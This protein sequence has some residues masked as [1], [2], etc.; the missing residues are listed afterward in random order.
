M[1]VDDGST[2][3]TAQV[4]NRYK[5]ISNKIRVITHPTNQGVS[6]ARNTGNAHARGKYITII[7][8]DDFARPKFLE[9]V[10]SFMDKNPT[11][12][13]GIPFKD[14][15]IETTKNSQPDR[16]DYPF[17]LLVNDNSLGNVGNVFRRDFM[18]KHKIK[19]KNTYSCGEDYDFWMQMI[20]NGA[21]IARIESERSP[22]VFRAYGGLSR[23]GN[24]SYCVSQVKEQLLKKIKYEPVENIKDTCMAFW[25]VLDTFPNLLLPKDK[26]TEFTNYCP[27]RTNTYLKIKHPYWTDFLIFSTYA[28][29][30]YRHSNQDKATILSF[31]PKNKIV[32]KWEKWG[33]ETFIYNKD[34]NCYILK[35]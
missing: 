14:G 3:H 9:T 17:Y 34:L 21:Q 6:A 4:L 13:I 7:D 12:T 25:H 16:W 35:K 15:Y 23:T 29:H 30:A 18:L 5:K 31:I 27:A 10:V 24:C 22:I 2:D 1:I 20:L 32:L 19:Y 8:S 33:E 11:V 28:T 26:K